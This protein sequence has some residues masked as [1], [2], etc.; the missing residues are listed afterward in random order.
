MWQN[1]DGNYRVMAG[2]L[3]EGINYTDER[4]VNTTLNI[5]TKWSTSE[6]RE[7]LDLWNGPKLSR[8]IV[9]LRFI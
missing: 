6:P 8:E 3:E 4:T 9:N 7:I 1:R 5:A 2:N